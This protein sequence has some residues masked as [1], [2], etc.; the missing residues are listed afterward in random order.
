MAGS[1]LRG[2]RPHLGFLFFFEARPAEKVSS[3]TSPPLFPCLLNPFR[4]IWNLPPVLIRH[5]QKKKKVQLSSEHNMHFRHS[6]VFPE[7]V[8]IGQSVSW[9]RRGKFP[10]INAAKVSNAAYDNLYGGQNERWC[11]LHRSQ[12]NGTV[13][14]SWRLR[15]TPGSSKATNYILIHQRLNS[16]LQYLNLNADARGAESD[17]G[18]RHEFNPPPPFATFILYLERVMALQSDRRG[19]VF[20]DGTPAAMKHVSIL[21]SFGAK[22][23]D[24]HHS[25]ICSPCQATKPLVS[26]A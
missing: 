20:T 4:E 18:C 2:C 9:Q 8:N 23:E 25:D 19:L 1:G 15:S 17:S 3:R 10:R 14:N 16:H 12:Y 24:W 26:L 22:R 7:N 21:K 13:V 6:T 11:S 5:R